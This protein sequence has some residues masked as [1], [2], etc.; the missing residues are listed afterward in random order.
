[1]VND[2]YP[3]LREIVGVLPTIA[4]ACAP[5]IMPK[6][7]FAKNSAKLTKKS[8]AKLRTMAKQ[9]AASNCTSIEITGYATK[10]K[11]AT[12]RTNAVMTY[13]RGKLY[14]ERYMVTMNLKKV[15]GKKMKMRRAEIAL[16]S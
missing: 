16:M 12:K 13:L 14:N 2:G 10:S 6:I 9:I 3:Y 1:M 15:H 11:L 7:G 5:V 8:K 4:P